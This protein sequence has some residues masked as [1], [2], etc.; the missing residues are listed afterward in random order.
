MYW[1]ANVKSF[2]R[3]VDAA[4]PVRTGVILDAGRRE[5]SRTSLFKTVA[6]QVYVCLAAGLHSNPSVKSL[7]ISWI[8]FFLPLPT[9]PRIP[10]PE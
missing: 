8:G 10:P 9:G 2:S 6:L 4:G 1:S 7:Q 5:R 3:S